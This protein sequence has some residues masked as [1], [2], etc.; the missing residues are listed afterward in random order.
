MKIKRDVVAFPRIE[1][2]LYDLRSNPP[3]SFLSQRVNVRPKSLFMRS[4][5]LNKFNF[6]ACLQHCQTLIFRRDA[7]GG[8]EVTGFGDEVGSPL[9]KV[10]FICK[11]ES[12]FNLLLHFTS[13]LLFAYLIP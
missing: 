11:F 4:S 6:D 7:S 12:R 13:S 8:K 9:S 3:N 5:F 2:L 1:H 10:G